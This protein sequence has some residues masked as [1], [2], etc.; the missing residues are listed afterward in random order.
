MLAPWK[1]SNDNLD[2]VL[3][4]REITLL[5]KV[6][7]VKAMLLLLF[8][9]SSS[10]TW[11]WELDDKKAESQRIDSLELWYW[12]ILESPLDS[13]D[14]K[15]VRFKGKDWYWSWSS[16]TLA[17]PPDVKSL[18][19]GKDPYAEKD[20][21]QVEECVPEDRMVGW[22][23]RLNGHE[24]EQIMS[25]GNNEGQG[26]LACYSPWVHK[27]WTQLSIW[28][29]TTRIFHSLLWSTQSMTLS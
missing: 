17:W 4:S 10:H 14:I 2:S 5:S 27:S 20:W 15:P 1:K 7:I 29:T 22:H 21:R 6:C 12:R 18:L 16:S 25:L 13:K 8:F 9:F 19:S 11:I 3:K 23:H 24:F 26:S 28:T